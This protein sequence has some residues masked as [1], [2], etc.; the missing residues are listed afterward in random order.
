L[1]VSSQFVRDLLLADFPFLTSLASSERAK[2]RRIWLRIVIDHFIATEPSDSGMIAAF[3]EAM[4][5]KLAAA[6]PATRLE[7]A[8]KLAPCAR[9]PA[10]LLAALRAL[11]PDASD[12]VLEH[13]VACSNGELEQA[14]ANGGQ[15]AIAVARRKNLDPH[16]VRTLTSNDDVLVLVA[17]ASNESARLEGPSLLDLLRRARR[18]AEQDGDRRLADALLER[19]PI[20]PEHAAL[21]LC[22]QPNQRIEI[23][24]AVQRSQLGRSPSSSIPTRS[25]S[26]DDLE[27]AA[28]A[29]QPERFV[30]LLA[31][32]LDCSR[33]LAH[34]IVHDVTGE[35]L[36]VALT[37][38]GAANEVLVRVLISND[39]MA[40]A[41]YQRIR[42]LAR[43]NNAL[44]RNAAIMVIDAL[45]DDARARRG[46]KA[47]VENNPIRPAPF[48]A[49]AGVAKKGAGSP[50]RVL[51]K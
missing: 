22:A 26:L 5:A 12:C 3:V 32:A 6:D 19:G 30:A 37:A 40:G 47:L 9:A 33:E 41:T 7:I 11:D 34:A 28:V 36:A 23:L 2:D 16:I 4:T 13:A 46:R 43:L 15:G 18:L 45:R 51:R 1:T 35:P 31:E 42:A 27:L 10:R 20:G 48:P 8:R 25:T 24:L 44:N 49:S 21:F 29:R 14:I 39:L 50:L 38:L 17:L